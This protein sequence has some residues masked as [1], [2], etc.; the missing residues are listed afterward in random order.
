MTFT[1]TNNCAYTVWPAAAPSSSAGAIPTKGFVLEAGE[2]RRLEAPFGWSGSLWGRTLCGVDSGG[3]FAC[4]TGDCGGSAGAVECSG[5]GAWH[6]PTTPLEFTPRDAGG[7]AVT[8]CHTAAS[9]IVVSIPACHAGDPG[10]IPG[11]GHAAFGPTL[12]ATS[13]SC[14]ALDAH[15]FSLQRRILGFPSLASW[16]SSR[17]DSGSSYG[18]SRMFP[19]SVLS[20]ET[21]TQRGASEKRVRLGRSY[22]WSCGIYAAGGSG[23]S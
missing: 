14:L 9:G 22:R 13:R 19:I 15:G 12:F 7:G 23:R 17:Q 4:A 3:R 18:P 5:G 11:N 16:R 10:S 20:P 21:A 6:P 2:S 1:F 8:F